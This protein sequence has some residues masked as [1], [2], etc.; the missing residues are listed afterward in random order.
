MLIKNLV[1]VLTDPFG[2]SKRWGREEFRG[3]STV[4]PRPKVL[5][6][7]SKMEEIVP[8]MARRRSSE[9]IQKEVS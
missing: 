8:K 9:T 6:H 2:P 1:V 5:E 7:K 4:E 3:D